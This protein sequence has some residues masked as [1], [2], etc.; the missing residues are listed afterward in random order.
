MIR[1]IK[2]YNIEKDLLNLNKNVN[3]VLK[4]QFRIKTDSINYKINEI[5]KFLKN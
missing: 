3:D 5:S 1:I 4:K 2:K